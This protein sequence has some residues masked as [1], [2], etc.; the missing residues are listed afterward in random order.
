MKTRPQET[1][2][3]KIRQLKQK[4]KTKPNMNKTLRSEKKSKT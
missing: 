4:P 3:I 2:K 1:K